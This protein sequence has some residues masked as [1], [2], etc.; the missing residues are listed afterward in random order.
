MA[1]CSH[2]PSVSR[3]AGGVPLEGLSILLGPSGLQAEGK[4]GTRDAIVTFDVLQPLS[5]VS[6]ECFLFPPSADAIVRV[7]DFQ[8]KHRNVSLVRVNDAQVRGRFLGRLRVELLREAHSCV[9]VL[10]LDVLS[11]WAFVVDSERSTVTLTKSD[12]Q[13][14]MDEAW[15]KVPLTLEPVSDIPLLPIR[16]RLADRR[17]PLV[18]GFS[19]ANE[20]RFFER[21]LGGETLE[22]IEVLPGLHVLMPSVSTFSQPTRFDGQLGPDVWGKVDGVIDFAAAAYWARKPVIEA[23]TR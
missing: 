1:G 17:V 22:A 7:P 2:A 20:T 8:R 16:L 9:L 18:V 19:T 11:A 14:V 10:G 15:V 6:E 23:P 4:V 3:P 21:L 13:R 12:S 5:A